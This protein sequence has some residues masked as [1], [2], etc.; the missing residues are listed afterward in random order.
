M[1][2]NSLFY[3]IM[4]SLALCSIP[5]ENYAA[6]PLP[7]TIESQHDM[8]IKTEIVSVGVSSQKKF[9]VVYAEKIVVP[10]VYK[11]IE[12]M[13]DGFILQGSDKKY[14]V[15]SP[16]GI[17]TIPPLYDEIELLEGSTVLLCRIKYDSSKLITSKGKTLTEGYYRITYGTN[18]PIIVQKEKT[19]DIAFGTD[20]KAITPPNMPLLEYDYSS[21]TVYAPQLIDGSIKVSYLAPDGT[22][23]IPTSYHFAQFLRKMDFFLTEIKKDTVTYYGAIDRTG[24]VLIPAEYDELTKIAYN[25][26][27]FKNNTRT[28]TASM[29]K[30]ILEITPKE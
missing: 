4:L 15:V 26:Y 25:I 13:T 23:I 24:K 7:Y 6:P 21:E 1:K 28:L 20:G 18:R 10:I 19:G 16:S 14:S 30:E 8:G 11:S 9:G 3:F 22:I 5:T 29:K 2:K 12:A 27:Q 17:A